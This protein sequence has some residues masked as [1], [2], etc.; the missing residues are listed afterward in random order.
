M[1]MKN[2]NDTFGNRTRDLPAC[3]A[4][5]QPSAP[6]RALYKTISIRNFR[7][8]QHV[9]DQ[10]NVMSVLK[11]WATKPEVHISF[12]RH[13]IPCWEESRCVGRLSWQQCGIITRQGSVI[14]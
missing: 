11:A 2:S 8:L 14:S 6:P 10:T 7:I 4:V 12:L 13:S 9:T 1:S 3:S 5:A